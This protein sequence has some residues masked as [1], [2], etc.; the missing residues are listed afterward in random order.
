MDLQVAQVLMCTLTVAIVYVLVG[1]LVIAHVVPR[2]I[3]FTPVA[4]LITGMGVW[5]MWFVF[6][7]AFLGT[8]VNVFIYL[9]SS[10][11][12]FMVMGMFKTFRSF[13]EGEHFW[14]TFVLGL[15]LF[16]PL[17]YV[18]ANDV[19]NNVAELGSIM[20]NFVQVSAMGKIPAAENVDY[21]GMQESLA[22]L[23]SF[24]PIILP[25]FVLANG[26]LSGVAAMFNLI[27]IVGAAG[28]LI[29]ASGLQ[30]RWSNLPLITA[31]SLLGVTFCNP[32]F[33]PAFVMTAY[34]DLSIAIG[35]LI[36]VVPVLSKSSIPVGLAV[37]PA[38][39]AAMV[40]ALQSNLMWPFLAAVLGLWVL[41]SLIIEDGRIRVQHMFGWVLLATLPTLMVL[42]WR[43]VYSVEEISAMVPLYEGSMRFTFAGSACAFILG[44]FVWKL[45]HL[46]EE[47]GIRAFWYRN[48]SLFVAAMFIAAAS[49]FFVGND[50]WRILGMLQFVLLLPLWKVWIHWYYNSSFREQAYRAP[51][52]MGSILILFFIGLLM[53]TKVM[54]YTPQKLVQQHVEQVVKQNLEQEWLSSGK[55]LGVVAV[56]SGP[57]AA[58][59][60]AMAGEVN[61]QDVTMAFI[62]A[63][64]DRAIF[65]ADLVANNISFLWLHS[66]NS[67]ANA[68]FQRKLREDH[69]YLF[70]VTEHSFG[71]VKSFP[72][73]AYTGSGW[74]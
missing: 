36:V 49:V 24:W 27:L 10:V 18:V 17:W 41:R 12:F 22:A 73:L 26:A 30:V 67:L 71:L 33:S 37:L 40:V 56:H 52:A 65:H 16:I 48:G 44:L 25:T 3:F 15:I 57:A 72:H 20:K 4:S 28:A 14:T 32:F 38:A 13:R 60:Y 42:L 9:F 7:G 64:G 43:Q 62:Q 66:S 31:G 68:M 70:E 34:P 54:W 19:P 11:V 47:R 29:Q 50:L 61:T 46:K 39:M 74:K 1:R 55:S 8:S 59:S 69:S 2:D 45:M 35:M 6:V 51:W 23:P 63:K 58:I 5:F 21:Y 53:T